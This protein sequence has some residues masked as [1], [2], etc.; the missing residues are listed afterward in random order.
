MRQPRLES[1][2]GSVLQG[3]ARSR[4]MESRV[5]FDDFIQSGFKIVDKADHHVFYLFHGIISLR[6][7]LFCCCFIFDLYNYTQDEM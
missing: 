2:F 7:R 4:K 6:K 1:Y 5:I 3:I